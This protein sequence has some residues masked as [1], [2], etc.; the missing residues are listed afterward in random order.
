[1]AT[2]ETAIANSALIKV[3][4]SR[5]ISLDDDSREARIVKEQYHKIL[6]K[7]LRSHPWNFAIVRVMLAA[8]TS[9]PAWGYD[10][11]YQIPSACVR[12]LGIDAQDFEWVREGN[13]IRTDS[14]SLGIR[15]VSKDVEAG[16][17]D[18]CFAEAF[19][20]KLAE[21]ICYSF[22]ESASLK[23][24][25]GKEFKDAIREAR[26]FDAQEGGTVRV[27]AREWLNSRN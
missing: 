20:I 18:A 1:M 9:E 14:T 10:K 12:V 19:A 13:V 8:L 25:L 26:S 27:Y 16:D 21:D 7:L 24:S 3:G 6:E 15:Y 11:E 2:S 4:G 5:I 17:F 22:A 23:E